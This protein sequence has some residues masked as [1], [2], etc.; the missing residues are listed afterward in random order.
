MVGPGLRYVCVCVCVKVF[1]SS[2][3]K[4]VSKCCDG[5]IRCVVLQVICIRLVAGDLLFG[6]E[7][8]VMHAYNFHTLSP[9][10]IFQT[11]L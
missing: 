11:N 6:G 10:V 7:L 4:I 8:A 9:Y 5:K 3:I 2:H 1:S